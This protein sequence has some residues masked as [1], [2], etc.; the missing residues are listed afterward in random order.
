[1]AQQIRLFL[2]GNDFV[3]SKQ[4]RLTKLGQKNVG[5]NNF[6]KIMSKKFGLK[7]L[8]IKL[9]YLGQKNFCVKKVG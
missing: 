2:P 3:C 4:L 9:F 8:L 6:W 5:Q 1:M 7:L